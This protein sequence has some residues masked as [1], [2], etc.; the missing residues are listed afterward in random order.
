MINKNL[1]IIIIIFTIIIVIYSNN[2]NFS[3]NNS[4]L[5]VNRNFNNNLDITVTGSCN[6][7]KKTNNVILYEFYGN[8]TFT[9]PSSKCINFF[10]IGGGGGGSSGIFGKDSI[11]LAGTGGNS[12]YVLYNSSTNYILPTGVY[13]IQVGVGGTG[14]FTQ[15]NGQD[16]TASIITLINNSN[17]TYYETIIAEANGG[18]GGKNNNINYDSNV[19]TSIILDDHI[20]NTYCNNLYNN[21]I[22]NGINSYAS[23][24]GSNQDNQGIIGHWYNINPIF[25]NGIIG[26][27]GNGG[28]CTN[29][30]KSEITYGNGGDGG[31]GGGM[32]NSSNINYNGSNGKNGCVYMWIYT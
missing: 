22:N 4:N 7:S 1:I 18:K 32:E 6:V 14:G 20:N 12:G 24:Y 16:G 3:S 30:I 21:N 27:G 9:L 28:A 25:I 8:G 10:I 15:I 29:K 11:A 26:S 2:E 5:I 17:G 19:F 13:N 23:R 31:Q